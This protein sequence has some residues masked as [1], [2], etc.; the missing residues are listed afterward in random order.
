MQNIF[1]GLIFISILAL[2]RIRPRFWCRFIC[3]FG[4]LLA[5]GSTTS[6]IQRKLGDSCNECNICH[7]TCQGAPAKEGAKNWNPQECFLCFN[8]QKVC[9]EKAISFHVKKSQKEI[10]P[11][12]STL[13]PSRRA[14]L[15]ST[16]A[17][18]A[19]VPVIHAA[20]HKK[21]SNPKLIRPPG[22]LPENDF[23]NRCVRCGE[24]MK[25]CPANGLQPTLLE[26]GLEGIWS[27]M[28][29]MRLGYCEYTCTLC[30]QVCP[31]GAIQKLTE[32][33]KKDV[34]IGL[35]FIDVS[36]C[37]PYA[38]SI[39]CI[40]CEEHCPTPDKA[41]VFEE[42]EIITHDGLAKTLKFPRVDPLRCIGCGICEN[43]CPVMDKR[44]I[45]I[46]SVN[47][48]RNEDNQVIL[49]DQTSQYGY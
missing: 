8:C 27:P 23:I 29:N 34:K 21:L 24:C 15:A 5:V 44:A 39:S 18:L 25:V 30:G 42:K 4:A 28:F 20:P 46:T 31:T 6:R 33:Q 37:L 47:E 9:P 35:A 45:Y 41:I 13:L 10:S 7:A 36:R 49:E 3:P 22:S 11:S 1:I 19:V 2:N 38:F 26:A 32:Q 14:F 40:V 16:A 17:S 43:K 12:L 48:T